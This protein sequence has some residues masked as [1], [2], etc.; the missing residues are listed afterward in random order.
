MPRKP[1]QANSAIPAAEQ[2]RRQEAGLAIAGPGCDLAHRVAAR[3]SS[4]RAHALSSHWPPV[5]SAKLAARK[6]QARFRYETNRPAPVLRPR[7]PQIGPA[8]SPRAAARTASSARRGSHPKAALQCRR[9]SQRRCNQIRR[10]RAGA[11][12][13]S[14]NPHE[15]RARTIPCEEILAG[16]RRIKKRKQPPVI[17]IMPRASSRLRACARFLYS[18][19]SAAIQ[20]IRRAIRRT[21]RS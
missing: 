14:K 6:R 1:W 19:A 16:F 7:S 4:S 21:D 3:R 9:H 12:S 11:G 8:L 20:P 10:M 15:R 5:E 18:G 13:C 2:Q 17:G